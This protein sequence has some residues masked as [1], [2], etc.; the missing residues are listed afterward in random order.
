MPDLISIHGSLAILAN[1]GIRITPSSFRS[2]VS[3]ETLPQPETTIAGTRFWDE[4]EMRDAT[5][6]L[7]AERQH[8]E[9]PE[10]DAPGP[11]HLTSPTYIEEATKLSDAQLAE[12]IMTSIDEQITLLLSLVSRHQNRR[13]TIEQQMLSLQVEQQM[14]SLL[15][16]WQSGRQ[17]RQLEG[18]RD[19]YQEFEQNAEASVEALLNDKSA[20]EAWL[21]QLYR[22]AKWRE[23]MG[24]R[25][26]E[27]ASYQQAR[28][29][30]GHLIAR[31]RDRLVTASEWTLENP[32][33]LASAWLPDGVKP[34]EEGIETFLTENPQGI[35]HR[36]LGGADFAYRWKGEP[37]R[38]HSGDWR[39]SWVMGTSEL[40]FTEALSQHGPNHVLPVCTTPAGTSLDD[41]I[42]WLLPFEGIAK[43]HNSVGL[44]LEEAELQKRCDWPSLT[45]R[46]V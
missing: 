45:K 42:Q 44:V 37:L 21:D 25:Q 33:R 18:S 8:N 1:S 30:L 2:Y 35:D 38:D 28:E 6:Q 31:H 36:H 26:A 22:W 32:R 12:K 3:R 24:E 46:S 27:S 4:H 34:T 20:T 19:I 14:L 5:K 9:P 40:Y 10:V 23:H 7:H 41:M 11:L 15:Q 43:E 39:L 16:R 17:L 13:S 29:D